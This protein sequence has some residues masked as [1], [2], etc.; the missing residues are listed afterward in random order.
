MAIELYEHQLAAIDK[1]KSGSILVG[2]VGSGKSRAGLAYYYLKEC[3]GKVKINGKGGHAPMRKPKDLYIIT[4]ARKRD[5]LEWEK[6]LVGFPLSQIEVHIDSWHNI[7]KYK[8][9]KGAFFL[10]DEQKV[11]GNGPWVKSFL[12]IT[13]NN[14]WL[15]LTATPGDTWMDYIPVFIANGFYK[16]RTEF[17]RRH[18]V[19]NSFTK[20]PKV[21]RFLEVHRLVRLRDSIIVN[22]PYKKRTIAHEEIYPV[23]F[24]KEKFDK[25]LVGRWNIYEKRPIKNISEM[26]Y[27]L[28]RVVN[29]DPRRIDILSMLFDKHPKIVVFYNFNYERDLLI[30]MAN[31]NEIEL[32]EWN[33]H[34]HEPIPTSDKWIYIVQY[35][36]GAEGWNCVETD[37]LVLYSQS[38]SYKTTVQAM[39]RTDRLDT[40]YEHLY[41]YRFRSNSII[42]L[43][44]YRAYE[45]KRDFNEL[46]FMVF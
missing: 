31:K 34:K 43:S 12:R 22:M 42:D 41:Y 14:R 9:I 32:A 36:A 25:V 15:I 45:N 27:I 24:D 3:L 8:H 1:L 6:E 11:I 38:Y 10:F 39:G 46:R 13:Q 33:G 35:T 23:P 5:T 4:T 16:N 17:I 20:F 37:T 2:R 44:I 26:C 29:S 21:E 30:E 18:V 7:M 28:R 40:P 19:Y